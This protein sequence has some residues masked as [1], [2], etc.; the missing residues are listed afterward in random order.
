MYLAVQ[1]EKLEVTTS[2][3][4]LTIKFAEIKRIEFGVRLSADE[5]RSAAAAVAQMDGSDEKKRDEA[6]KALAALKERAYPSL[7]KL[8]RHADKAV[9][10]KAKEMLAALRKS[11]SE[12]KLRA[13][14]RDLIHT[15]HSKIAGKIEAV[16]LRTTTPQFGEL[17][18]R[19]PDLAVV[20]AAGGF[21]VDDGPINILPDPG[22]LTNYQNEIGKTFYF[23][24]T[25]NPGGSVWGTD[26]YTTD[27]QLSTA[28]IHAGVLRHGET[29]V[30]RVTI[31]A[32]QN[33]YSGSSRNG[34]STSD[35]GSFQGS[36][37]VSKVG[38]RN[39]D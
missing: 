28:A 4:K 9:S 38:A 14:E 19:V 5:A 10:A 26:I 24:V 22:Y 33:S 2:Y 23:R 16:E 25:A 17:K 20:T 8:D 27:S 1:E 29:G 3:G 15:E 6:W 35:Y 39:D 11:V 18:L 21:A 36:Y 12:V 31:M 34:I 32:G 37:K 7:E 30:V 13:I